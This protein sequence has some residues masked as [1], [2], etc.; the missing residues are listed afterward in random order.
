V[1]GGA[2][3]NGEN[4]MS[5]TPKE[6]SFFAEADARANL[7][8]QI[9]SARKEVEKMKV[10]CPYIFPQYSRLMMAKDKLELAHKEYKEALAAWRA[11]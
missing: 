7:V 5:E 3:K 9:E 8:K 2:E 4:K 6:D 11:L 1:E 10:A